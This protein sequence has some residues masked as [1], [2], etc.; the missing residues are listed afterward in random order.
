MNQPIEEKWS[1]EFFERFGANKIWVKPSKENVETI[2]EM[3]AFFQQAITT[4]VAKAEQE[5]FKAGFDRGA[6]EKCTGKH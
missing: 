5:A 1:K 2:L 3:W 6:Q 4:A